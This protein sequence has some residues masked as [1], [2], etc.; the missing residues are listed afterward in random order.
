M[1]CLKGH[2]L[3]L[4]SL[5]TLTGQQIFYGTRLIVLNEKY[6]HP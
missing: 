3:V 5:E 6:Y 4:W 2:H 1:S